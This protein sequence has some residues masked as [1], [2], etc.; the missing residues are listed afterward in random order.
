MPQA[1]RTIED[2]PAEVADLAEVAS[3]LVEANPGN[4]QAFA[5]LASVLTAALGTGAAV[6]GAA[7]AATSLPIVIATAARVA[8]QLVERRQHTGALPRR[9][10]EL[11]KQAGASFDAGAT[12]AVAARAAAAFS[13]LV[14]R[15]IAGDT[16][17][18][19][20]L[21]VDRSRISQRLRDR[22]LYAFA[23]PESRCFPRWQFTDGHTLP[24]LR[25]ALSALDAELH[26]LV[27]DHWFSTPSVDLELENGPV[28]P[29]T[30]LA[31]GGNPKRVVEL[32]SDL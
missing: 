23:Q 20:L 4:R 26:P 14:A 25:E 24:G 30:W 28:S 18:A 16:A 1:M 2:V 22:S 5:E 11:W 32:A 19:E 3:R 15:S 13:D 31:T 9:E 7:A 6:A 12:D 8:A 27:V 29:V 21:S 17:V 10:Q